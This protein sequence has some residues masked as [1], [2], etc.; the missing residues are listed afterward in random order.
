[1]DINALLNKLVGSGNQSNSNL[2]LASG[3]LAGGALALLMGNKNVKKLAGTA[4]SVGGMALLGGMAAKAFQNWQNQ[5]SQSK[6]SSLLTQDN[7]RSDQ[8]ERELSIIKAMVAAA[9]ADGHIDAAEQDRIFKQ[10]QDYNLSSE[11]KALIFDL[12][13][14]PSNISEICSSA[15]TIEHKAEL[16]LASRLVC[17]AGN[18]EQQNPE[19]QKY[20][21]SLAESLNLPSELVKKLDQQA[22]LV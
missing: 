6:E 18:S 11:E 16:Y 17:S 19:E 2:G 4:A 3:A 5:N 7:T 1:M 22:E 12:I 14:K 10:A 20:L 8:D 9:K 21:A 15:K 13:S